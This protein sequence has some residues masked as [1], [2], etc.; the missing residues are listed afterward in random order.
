VTFVIVL[1]AL[2][3]TGWASARF[4]RV[5]PVFPAAR[6]AAIGGLSMLITFLVGHVLYP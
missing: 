2:A 4:S 1:A 3:L 5:N 6:T